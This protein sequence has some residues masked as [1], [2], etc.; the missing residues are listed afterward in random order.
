[1]LP[2]SPKPNALCPALSWSAFLTLHL[3][4]T[5]NASCYHASRLGVAKF[6][7]MFVPVQLMMLPLDPSDLLL[8]VKGKKCLLDTSEP[9]PRAVESLKDS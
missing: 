6:L 7:Y 2:R 5:K 3:G 8:I 4:S 1:M 9:R